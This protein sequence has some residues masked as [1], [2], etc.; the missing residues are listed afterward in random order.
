MEITAICGQQTDHLLD[1]VP[2]IHPLVKDLKN[3]PK[4]DFTAHTMLA[5]MGVVL[6]EGGV[7]EIQMKISGLPEEEYF[8]G[9]LEAVPERMRMKVSEV[10][11]SEEKEVLRAVRGE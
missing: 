6:E 1:A 11:E 10:E 7:R 9:T 8:H 5:L 3:M 2:M 4:L